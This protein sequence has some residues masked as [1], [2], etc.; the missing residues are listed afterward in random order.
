MNLPLTKKGCIKHSNLDSKKHLC[1][2]VQ[3]FP[4]QGRFVSRLTLQPKPAKEQYQFSANLPKKV[5][6]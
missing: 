4:S 2:K 3:L 6:G 1:Q 5:V